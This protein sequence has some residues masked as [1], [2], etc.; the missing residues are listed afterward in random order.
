MS[1]HAANHV[2]YNKGSNTITH[3]ESRTP[4][5]LFTI[6]LLWGYNN[7]WGSFTGKHVQS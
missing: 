3:L 1:S 7:D 6:Q 4:I 2:T 5:C